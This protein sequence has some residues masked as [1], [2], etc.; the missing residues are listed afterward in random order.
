V[1]RFFEA[2][3]QVDSGGDSPLNRS[4]AARETPGPIRRNTPPPPISFEA[5]PAQP[6]EKKGDEWLRILYIIRKHWQISV[7]SA[8]ALMVT[9]TV[10]T[11]T[12]KPIYE[13]VARIEVD[14]PGETFSLNGA[15]GAGD[16]EYLQTQAQNLAS[17]KL[18]VAVIH[19]LHLDQ[20]PEIVGPSGN[21]GAPGPEAEGAALGAFHA[22]L[23]IKRD[24]SSRL[25]SVSFGCHDPRLAAVV[26]N[27]VLT[28]FI[29]QTYQNQH[30]AIMTST[31]WLSR[32]LDDIR[33][34][35]ENSNKALAEYQKSIGVADVDANRSTF[36]E[37]LGELNR[38]LTQ[39]EADR[40]QLQAL[41]RSVQAGGPDALPEVRSNPVVQRLSENLAEK[42]AELAQAMVV[43]GK[44]HPAVKKL[45]GE[46]DELN[47]QLNAQKAAILYSIK[48]S[49]SAAQA[50]EGL[51][52]SEI[53]SA[54]GGLNQMARYNELKKEALANEELY[55]TL[56]A[57]IKEAGIAA[58]SKSSNLRIVDE[59]RVL[60]WPSRP[61]RMLNLS[62]G[63]IL[64]LFV[65]VALALLCEQFDTRLFTPEEFSQCIGTS[66][67]A[68]IPHFF[69]TDP[70]QH[71]LTGAGQPGLEGSSSEKGHSRLASGVRFLLDYPS[72]P[73]AEAL[74]YLYT[75]V[76][77]SRAGAPPQALLVVSS[78]PGEGKTTVAINL[79]I[80]MAQHGSTC[81]V[82]ADLRRGGVAAAFGIS[83]SVGLSDVLT[84]SVLLDQ[85]L[86]PIPSLSNLT[87]VPSHPNSNGGQLVCSEKMHSVVKQLRSRFR[88]VVI[89]CAPLLPFADGRLLST[90]VDGLIF[91]G[92]AGI[93]TRD[94]V[95][96]SLESLNEV[97]A[98]PVLEF[99]L[100][101][102]DFNS[103]QYKYYRYRY[104][105]GDEYY[106][107]PAV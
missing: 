23:N 13:P 105:Y 98:A 47:N 27:A 64:S 32:Q 43:Y 54:A 62:A 38:Q 29:E 58:A 78:F 8:A 71:Q 16:A 56:Y 7:L 4:L 20:N 95:R 65:G 80:A 33:G 19:K 59:A 77:L 25:I 67:I 46:T 40:I 99:V 34:R 12:T 37:K 76:M 3:Q 93:T 88:F 82:D 73:E 89:D 42:R 57:K 11:F 86:S 10:V 91:V 18:A 24:T 26:T 21:Q 39:A 79:A 94:V 63:L 81:I 51:M 87:V 35:M 60:D 85:V 66:N 28:T 17:D 5:R 45:Q 44:N 53:K 100:N 106:Q 55:N 52:G 68:I 1:S 69:A 75:S 103:P 61:N 70:Y 22:R 84:G 72:A 48:T 96:R 97:Q 74:R 49:Y 15:S 30:D 83:N 104:G 2:A 41:L 107:G 36:S 92:R 6:Q 14:P 101:A 9:V 31:E 102:A 90:L 50:R